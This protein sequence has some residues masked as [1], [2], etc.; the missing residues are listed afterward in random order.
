MNWPG[1][2]RETRKSQSPQQPSEALGTPSLAHWELIDDCNSTPKNSKQARIQEDNLPSSSEL[3]T[4][5]SA[6]SV[7]SGTHSGADCPDSF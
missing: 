1:R 5:Q 7:E 4:T 6:G 2:D 3:L